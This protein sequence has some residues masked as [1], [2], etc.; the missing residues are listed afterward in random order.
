MWSGRVLCWVVACVTMLKLGE[1]E[2]GIWR[3]TPTGQVCNLQSQRLLLVASESSL[4][5]QNLDIQDYS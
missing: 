4:K 3:H 1:G 2:R 5:S